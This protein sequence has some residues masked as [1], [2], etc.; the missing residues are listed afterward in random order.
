MTTNRPQTT[1]S[2][3]TQKWQWST[4]SLGQILSI[5]QSFSDATGIDP[6]VIIGKTFAE[7]SLPIFE[8]SAESDKKLKCY[9]EKC[10]IRKSFRN[11]ELPIN[12]PVPRYS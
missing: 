2:T 6:K 7:I 4:D 3:Q 1:V 11:I 9:F 12:S 8:S 5:S 10:K